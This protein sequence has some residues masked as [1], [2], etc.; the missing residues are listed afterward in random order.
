MVLVV[1]YNDLLDTKIKW[2]Y[3]VII[4][5]YNSKN[6]VHYSVNHLMKDI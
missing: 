5:Y 6:R 3:D 4:Y 2:D 1:K